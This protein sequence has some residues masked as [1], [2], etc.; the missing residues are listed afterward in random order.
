[1]VVPVSLQPAEPDAAPL[2]AAT[3]PPFLYSMPTAWSKRG[4][5]VRQVQGRGLKPLGG[6][7][8]NRPEARCALA[9]GFRV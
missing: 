6:G 4:E 8:G 1:M 7:W 9:L 2:A 3:M 5:G